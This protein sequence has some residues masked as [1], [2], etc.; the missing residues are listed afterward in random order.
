[1]GNLGNTVHQFCIEGRPQSTFELNNVRILGTR[2]SSAIKATMQ[3]VA[4]RHSLLSVS[5][6]PGDVTGGLLMHTPIDVPAVSQ[7]V[8]YARPLPAV[9]GAAGQ[10]QAGPPRVVAGA[11]FLR[12]ASSAYA[13]PTDGVSRPV[14]GSAAQLAG[15]SGA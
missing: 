1:M 11:V 14:V 3:D 7:L 6:K 12:C 5:E 4:V 10:E 15:S 8:V 2:G 9:P 13:D